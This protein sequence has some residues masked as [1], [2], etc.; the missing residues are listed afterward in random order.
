M[1]PDDKKKKKGWKPLAYDIVPDRI[2][3]RHHNVVKIVRV[4]VVYLQRPSIPSGVRRL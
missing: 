3:Y 4:S 1:A 2:D